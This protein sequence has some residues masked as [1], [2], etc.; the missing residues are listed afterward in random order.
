MSSKNKKTYIC[1]YSF[2]RGGVFVTFE[3]HGSLPKLF[4]LD[5]GSRIYV[6]GPWIQEPGSWMPNG[7]CHFQNQAVSQSDRQR[8]HRI[9]YAYVIYKN[10]CMCSLCFSPSLSIIYSLNGAGEGGL[11]MGGLV[12]PRVRASRGKCVTYVVSMS[13]LCIRCFSGLIRG[14]G[15]TYLDNSLCRESQLLL[16]ALI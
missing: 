8:P 10:I 16:T 7:F 9:H 5:H 2:V 14:Q 15:A 3:S 4:T 1:I 6:P 11:Q 12:F 13:V